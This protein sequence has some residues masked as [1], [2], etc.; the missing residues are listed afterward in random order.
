M[1]PDLKTGNNIFAL[2]Q[3]GLSVVEA[4]NM[5]LDP[6]LAE[7]LAKQRAVCKGIT[8]KGREA[9]QQSL[10]RLKQRKKEIRTAATN[11]A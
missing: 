1:Q 3:A 6:A 8:A 4:V 7:S 5:I 9:R 10:T 11:P 2:T